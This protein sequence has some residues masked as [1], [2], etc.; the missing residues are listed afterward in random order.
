MQLQDRVAII[1]G[2]GAG[3]G[4]A[5]C[6]LFAAEGAKIVAVDRDPA[7]LSSVDEEARRTGVTFLPVQADVSR[8][9]D[10]ER[11]VAEATKNFSAIHILFNNA[12]IVPKG[13]IHETTEEDWDRTMAVN[14]KSMYLMSH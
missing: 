7:A 1:T 2:A 9:A 4:R 3:I 13:K 6:L 8:A 14:V 10:V 12:G 11:V 5:C